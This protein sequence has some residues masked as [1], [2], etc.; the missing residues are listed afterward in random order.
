MRLLKKPLNPLIARELR[1]RARSRG[2][3]VIITLYL[4]IL[5]LVL[6]GLYRA[7]A[8]GAR[9]DVDAAEIATAG[10]TMF[11]TLL[12]FILVMVWFVVPGT[13]ASAISGERERQT[14]VPLQVT[15]LGPWSLVLGKLASSMMFLALLVVAALPLVG[16]TFI[17]GGVSIWEVLRGFG[18]VLVSGLAMACLALA[19]SSIVKRV[20]GSTVLAYFLSLTL[21]VGVFIMFALQGA[22]LRNFDGP[23]GVLY[24]NPFMAT[25]DVVIGDVALLGPAGESPSPFTPFKALVRFGEADD[26]E[27]EARAMVGGPDGGGALI[28]FWV[29]SVLTYGVMSGLALLVAARRLRTPADT[30][31]R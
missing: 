11:H 23:Q 14:L 26:D 18:M 25:A 28:P 13:T 6:Y 19:C 4:A 16:I 3:P 1:Q 7:V 10:R 5:T 17:L 9:G 24:P 22:L 27:A 8:E 29:K 12:F 21:L 31:G 20:Q 2:T 30:E 15:L